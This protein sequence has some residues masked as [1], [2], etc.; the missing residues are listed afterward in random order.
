[1]RA[2]QTIGG[3]PPRTCALK[4]ECVIAMRQRFS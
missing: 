4:I 2:T 3:C 1:V